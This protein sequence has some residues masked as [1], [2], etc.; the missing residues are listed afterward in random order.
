MTLRDQQSFAVVA[1]LLS[2]TF[3]F[4]ALVL[5]HRLGLNFIPSGPVALI[6]SII[7]QYSRI[8]PSV[9]SFR[10]FG[11]PLNNKSFNYV[12][13]LQVRAMI[14]RCSLALTRLSS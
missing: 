7:Y 2:T 6:F 13:A 8:V 10:V 3:N 11:V 1:T 12:L 14:F 9:Y 4:L 5:F